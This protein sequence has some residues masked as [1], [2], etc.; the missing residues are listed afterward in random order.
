MKSLKTLFY[1]VIALIIITIL[2]GLFYFLVL[3]VNPLTNENNENPCIQLSCPENTQFVGSLNSDKYHT[4][5]CRFA[6]QINQENI[7]CF[8]SEQQAQQQG[9]T[10][11]DC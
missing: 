4:C 2:G 6:K 8:T 11:S 10:S 1:L 5:N 9:Y 7:L 3:N